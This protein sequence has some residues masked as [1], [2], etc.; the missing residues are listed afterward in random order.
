MAYIRSFGCRNQEC[1]RALI[2][3][4]IHN[5]NP[6]SFVQP[7]TIGICDVGQMRQFPDTTGPNGEVGGTIMIGGYPGP[8]I[9]PNGDV[10][11][12]ILIGGYPGTIIVV[13]GPGAVSFITGGR[14]GRGGGKCTVTIIMGGGGRNGGNQTGGIYGGT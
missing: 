6:P 14:G 12:T 10:G 2:L 1:F 7:N 4:N 11:G 9:G 8:I 5:Q 3:M 13:I